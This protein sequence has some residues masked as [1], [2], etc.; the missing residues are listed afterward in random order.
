MLKLSSN[1]KLYK[2]GYRANGKPENGQ[3]LELREKLKVETELGHEK[4]PNPLKCIT[5]N[6]CNQ[7]YSCIPKPATIDPVYT[8]INRILSNRMHNPTIEYPWRGGF[9]CSGDS[10]TGVFIFF[11]QPR[12]PVS[13]YI[14]VI[15]LFASASSAIWCFSQIMCFPWCRQSEL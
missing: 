2:S 11:R 9:M 8:T 10:L 5:G 6:F 15:F 1:S 3:N 12:R 4:R 13:Q 14:G 7:T